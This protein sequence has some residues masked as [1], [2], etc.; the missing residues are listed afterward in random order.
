MYKLTWIL[1]AFFTLT[2]SALAAPV[3]E[4]FQD[5]EKRTTHTGRVR[6]FVSFYYS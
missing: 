5:L 1:V 3:P 4:E 6:I 2:L